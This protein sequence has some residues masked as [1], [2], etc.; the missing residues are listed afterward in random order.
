MICSCCIRRWSRAQAIGRFDAVA[1]Y[2]GRGSRSIPPRCKQDD[3][4][5][6]G[7]SQAGSRKDREPVYLLKG[8]ASWSTVA[9]CGRVFRNGLQV[10]ASAASVD[11]ENRPLM[12]T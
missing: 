2:F 4:A 7:C 11:T 9:D 10:L 6:S 12:D 5:H 1:R 8:P 3:P